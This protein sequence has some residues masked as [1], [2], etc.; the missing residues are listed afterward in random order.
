MKN[1][2]ILVIGLIVILISILYMPKI[3]ATVASVSLKASNNNPNAGE[4]VYTY[5]VQAG[6][7]LDLPVN[8]KL[9]ENLYFTGWYTD[10]TDGEKIESLEGIITDMALYARWE[11]TLPTDFT[12]DA[13]NILMSVGEIHQVE[14][15]FEPTGLFVFP[16]ILTVK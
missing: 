2:K 10:E 16:G 6:E 3:F 11:T 9:G 1:K 8:P 4:S 14:V 12:I 13:D 5:M 15:T 7:P